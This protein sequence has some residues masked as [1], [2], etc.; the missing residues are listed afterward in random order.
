VQGSATFSTA[1]A[2][3][4]SSHTLRL[5]GPSSTWIAGQIDINNDASLVVAASATLTISFTTGYAYAITGATTS[6]QV[7]N[8]GTIQQ[9]NA[10]SSSGASILPSFVNLGTGT[11]MQFTYRYRLFHSVCCMQQCL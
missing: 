9:T 1:L 3:S 11:Y 5:A 2:K 8:H 10:P 4:L 6:G 7:V